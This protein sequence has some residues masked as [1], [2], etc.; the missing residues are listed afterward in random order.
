[1]DDTG[2]VLNRHIVT[3]DYAECALT[4]IEPRDELMV[5]DAHKFG[6][7]E[8]AFKH[9]VRHKFVSR[10]VICK[11]DLLRLR[12]EQA[13]NQ[14]LCNHID[15]RVSGVRIEG[16]DPDIVY[17]RTDAKSRIGRKSPRG[18]GPCKE[19]HRKGSA[20]IENLR[21]LILY[22]LELNGRRGVLHITVA[23]RLIE[24]MCAQTGSCSR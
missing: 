13:R 9:P 22:H 2:T 12:V 16:L 17:V 8:L 1:M 21:F 11:R 20:A 3:R 18:R 6:S 15:A 19:E 24:F 23:S 10:L 5:G 7:L 14:G 4:R